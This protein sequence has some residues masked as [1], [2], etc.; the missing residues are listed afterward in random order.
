[1]AM[2]RRSIDKL[3]AAQS[4]SATELIPTNTLTS[5]SHDNHGGD[6]RPTTRLRLR[7]GQPDPGVSSAGCS[8]LNPAVLPHRSS[9]LNPPDDIQ[10]GVSRI[11]PRLDDLYRHLK[12]TR[13]RVVRG[14]AQYKIAG[15]LPL[16]SVPDPLI[17]RYQAETK[18]AQSARTNILRRLRPR[19]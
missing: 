4:P 10:S 14:T 11:Q 6:G 5:C 18:V 1:M 19:Q 12:I 16:K 13:K 8:T 3:Q 7:V 9:K 17:R 15:W 2:G